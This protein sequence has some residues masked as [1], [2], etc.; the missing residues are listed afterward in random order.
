MARNIAGHV[1]NTLERSHD[2]GDVRRNVPHGTLRFLA[3]RLISF[4]FCS[5]WN[6]DAVN[7]E[8]QP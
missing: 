8:P 7:R 5:T 6:V 3:F 4:R 2:K 1:E